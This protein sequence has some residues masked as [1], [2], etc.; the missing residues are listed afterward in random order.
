MVF[1]GLRREKES[2]KPFKEEIIIVICSVHLSEKGRRKN[3]EGA[4]K[5]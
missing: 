2:G 4:R 5:R 1:I 3:T